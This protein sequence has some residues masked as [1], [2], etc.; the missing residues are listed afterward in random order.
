M[1]YISQYSVKEIKEIISA[2][3]Y[4][5]NMA[6]SYLRHTYLARITENELWLYYTGISIKKGICYHVQ[7]QEM[8]EGTKIEGKYECS[9]DMKGGLTILQIFCVIAILIMCYKDFS[10]IIYFILPVLAMEGILY[11]VK[12]Y[13]NEYRYGKEV[14]FMESMVK[15]M[16]IEEE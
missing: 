15:M 9:S 14:E 4:P 16:E 11:K 7:M 1:K 12:K 3:T 8:A 2:K 6:N 13:E 10:D 5:I